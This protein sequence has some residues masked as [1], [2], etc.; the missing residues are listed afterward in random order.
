MHL[1][2]TFY[3]RA[4]F[5][6]RAHPECLAASPPPAAAAPPP[7]PPA[8]Q[9]IL[10][11]CHTTTHYPATTQ[12]P[13]A[14][15][16]TLPARHICKR[17]CMFLAVFFPRCLLLKYHGNYTFYSVYA[18]QQQRKHGGNTRTRSAPIHCKK[19]QIK[20]VNTKNCVLFCKGFKSY[21]N[22]VEQINPQIQK[23]EKYEGFP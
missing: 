22:E 19:M 6:S 15:A 14:E 18:V 8:P 9:L 16:A 5:L 7:F 4:L 23:V 17:P 2:V 12:P 11:V 1:L 20:N 10:C 13:T 21:Y 3:E